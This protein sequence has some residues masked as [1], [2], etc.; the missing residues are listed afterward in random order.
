MNYGKNSAQRR[1]KNITSKKETKEKRIS[2]HA[3]KAILLL[4]I[5]AIA[6]VLFGIYMFVTSILEDAPEISPDLVSPTAYSTSIVDSDGV[7]L[8]TLVESG[9]NRVYVS[10]DEIPQDL[11][12]AFV[13]IEDS[14]FWTHQGIDPI[15]IMRAGV[16]VITSASLSEGASTITQQLI[17]NSIFDFTSESSDLDSI[18]RKIQ[19]IYLALE[20]ETM[21]TKDSI[22]ECYLNTINMG[23][24]TLGV[25]AASLRY[26]NKEVIELNLTECAVLAAITNS[27]SYY[28]PITYP[29]DNQTRATKVLADMCTQGYI[30][31]AEKE[32]A[33]N[34][35][36]ETYALIQSVN[37]VYVEESSAYSY[38][39][40]ALISQVLEDLQE[41]L[42]YTYAQATSKLYSGGLTIVSA[43][44]TAIQAIV[45]EEMADDSNYP[46]TTEYQVSYVL[47]IIHD[48]DTVDNYSTEM[49]ETW[50]NTEFNTSSGLLYDS[51]EAAAAAVELY[52]ESL[53]ITED[54]TILEVYS[55]APQPQASF[56]IMDQETG[57]VK[58]LV[59]GR[60]TKETSLSLNRA[61]D[62]LRQPGSTFKILSTYAPAFDLGSYT[63]ASI[64]EDKP[65]TYTSGTAVSNSTN[66][67]AGNVT[68]RYAITKS[69]NTVAVQVLTDIEPSTGYEYI[70]DFGITSVSASEQDNQA[71]A[72]GGL[73]NGVT[74]LEL[75][76]AY[77]A[78]ANDGVYTEPILYTMIYDQNG[79]ILIDNEPETNQVIKESTA[80]LLTDAMLDVVTSGTGTKASIGS[81]AVAGK[82]GTTNDYKDIWF[83]GYTPYY[84][85]GIWGGYDDP[86]SMSSSTASWRN[87]LWAA[88][89]ERVHE[90]LP[91]VDFEMP[92]SV[93]Y[94]K[95]CSVSGLLATTNE[96]VLFGDMEDVEDLILDMAANGIVYT[97]EDPLL[98]T[99][100]VTCPS[101]YEYFAVGTQPTETCDGLCSGHTITDLPEPT[102]EEEVPEEPE[103]PDTGTTTTPDTGTTTTPDTGTTTTPDTGTTTTPDTGTTTTPDTDTDTD[104]DSSADS[105]SSTN[106]GIVIIQ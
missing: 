12:D 41:E 33:M 91:V 94:T 3:F 95:V 26:F 87:S 64:V 20:L 96:S 16:S 78:I 43:Q 82:T 57:E 36:D 30:T 2:I 72:L 55:T 7:V 54:D 67:Y 73:T 81:Q 63:L 99:G 93:V 106:S 83:V 71:M 79:D 45:D 76:A 58:A 23:Q 53:N 52:K 21:M 84:T 38:Y 25:Q 75:T 50:A 105:D 42:G 90:D 40:D 22:L 37:D 92:D 104:S 47:S 80:A 88:I 8:E 101:T 14:R 51:E 19:E 74:N 35:F 102:V 27:P 60:G 9:S 62:S 34:L 31:E 56:V 10:I 85:A 69:I 89:M 39:T 15:G 103:T 11:Q 66:S 48:D 98:L 77:A 4:I 18:E 6:A 70:L 68:L 5:I 86:T 29:E 17:K 65:T 28:N 13:A 100:T 61:T 49:F 24:N 97:L 32:D 46:S 1:Q 44:D 59:G